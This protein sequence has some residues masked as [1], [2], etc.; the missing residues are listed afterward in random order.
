LIAYKV[1]TYFKAEKEL[2]LDK[3]VYGDVVSET[4]IIA[5]L[6]KR[7]MNL[8]VDVIICILVFSP[9]I[10]FLIS[11]N[12]FN[13]ILIRLQAAT[14]DKI[15]LM[16]VVL[17]CRSLYYIFF[18]WLLGATPGKLLTETRVIKTD[19]SLPSSKTILGRTISRFVPFEA[20]S[21]VFGM[22]PW[23]DRWSGTAVVNEK[24]TGVKGWLYFG[25]IP[26]TLLLWYLSLWIGDEYRIMQY[27]NKQHQETGSV[28]RKSEETY[29]HNL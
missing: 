10:L 24:R 20:F 26:V 2:D 27:H 14:N 12:H 11:S 7:F 6:S 19:G 25:V 1:L 22:Y 13:N 16:V 9:V 15:A 17:F 29:Q 8:V 23:H 3:S 21:A 28:V 4:F 5:S 18:E